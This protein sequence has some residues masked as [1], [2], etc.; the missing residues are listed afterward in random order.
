M[1]QRSFTAID[2]VSHASDKTPLMD[3]DNI[4]EAPTNTNPWQLTAEKISV[5]FSAICLLVSIIW[6]VSADDATNLLVRISRETLLFSNDTDVEDG[7][8]LIHSTW[9]KHCEEKHS[10]LLQ[11]PM[12]DDKVQV[13]QRGLVMHSSIYAFDIYIFPLAFAVFAISIV[14][15]TWRWVQY[16]TSPDGTEENL[17]KLY[18][19]ELGPDFSRWLEYF[20]TSP[21][22]ILIVSS[23]FGFATVDSLLGQAGMQAALVLL[24][25]DIE[26]QIKKMY[27]RL[28]KEKDEGPNY[29]SKHLRF[30][31]IF[32]GI[33]IADIRLWVYLFFAWALHIAIWGIPNVTG[34]GIGGKYF[35][36]QK[37]LEKCVKTMKIPDA[38]TWIYWFQFVLFTL[39]GLVCTAHVVFVKNINVF[40]P[41]PK[42]DWRRISGLY[43]ILSVTAKTLLEAGLVSHVIMYNEW[44]VLPEANTQKHN[45]NNTTCWAITPAIIPV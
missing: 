13:T 43:S 42:R 34:F 15:Q 2:F 45:V 17:R 10:M 27:K 24:G 6:R 28:K 25:Y 41:N 20:F 33:R 38:I 26:R 37:Q 39:F 9:N 44:I 40:K 7:M 22:Q 32:S 4:S 35:L 29:R 8:R 5:L 36:L 21:L 30:H 19:P 23:S 31:H 11:V 18:K 12:W 3:G 14:F 1:V 16:D